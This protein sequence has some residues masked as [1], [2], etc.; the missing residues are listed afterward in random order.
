MRLKSLHVY[1][2]SFLLNFGS[3]LP[4]KIQSSDWYEMIPIFKEIVKVFKLGPN[5]G[6]LNFITYVF[7]VI[8]FVDRLVQFV[9]WHNVEI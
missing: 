5:R 8:L 7:S 3:I 1:S 9:N 6:E 2:Y 4:T